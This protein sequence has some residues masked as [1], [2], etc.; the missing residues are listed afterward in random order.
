MITKIVHG[1]ALYQA[2]KFQRNKFCGVSLLWKE[3][4]LIRDVEYP[5]CI[6]HQS[7]HIENGT[8]D[9]AETTC[10]IRDDVCSNVSKIHEP[11]RTINLLQWK[12]QISIL[13]KLIYMTDIYTQ[14]VDCRL[15]V[16]KNT[17]LMR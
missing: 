2:N 6:Y 12:K 17:N 13:V 7:F 1:I 15:S 3:A 14:R 5:A 11:H 16:I 10:S 8:E 4:Y 9:M